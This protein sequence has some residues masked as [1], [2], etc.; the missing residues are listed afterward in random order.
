MVAVNSLC[1]RKSSSKMVSRKEY[2]SRN[3]ILNS[4]LFNWSTC[5]SGERKWMMNGFVVMKL[6]STTLC[7]K[8]RSLAVVTGQCRSAY[9]K[10][11]LECVKL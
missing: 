11:K 6:P 10:N 2:V 3:Q 8:W 5:S 4:F 7:S 1:D 9:E